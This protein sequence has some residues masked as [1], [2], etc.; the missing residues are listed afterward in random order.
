MGSVGF[1]VVEKSPKTW[2][3]PCKGFLGLGRAHTGNPCTW[4]SGVVGA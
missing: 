3:D 2:D 4:G 1:P